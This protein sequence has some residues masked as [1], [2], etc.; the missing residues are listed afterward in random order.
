MS[1]IQGL[2][3]NPF[4]QQMVRDLVDI[5]RKCRAEVVAEGVENAR[6]LQLVRRMKIRYAQ[7]FYYARPKKNLVTAVTR[8]K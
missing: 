7:G 4:N 8:R 2:A 5:S 1:L 6:E 3:G